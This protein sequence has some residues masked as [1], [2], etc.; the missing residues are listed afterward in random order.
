MKKRVIALLLSVML[1]L[2]LAACGEKDDG[3]GKGS[4]SKKEYE[5]IAEDYVEAFFDGDSKAIIKL[6]DDAYFES[7]AKNQGD[8]DKDEAKE[9][10]EDTLETQMQAFSAAMSAVNAD[11][12]TKAAE[13]RN[14][15][16]DELEDIQSTLESS[17]VDVEIE[18]LKIVVVAVTVEAEVDGDK[19]KEKFE[20]E[21]P[22]M[23]VDG[24]WSLEFVGALENLGEA[25]ASL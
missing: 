24:E 13:S 15:S 2:T 9:Y 4:G 23:K 12:T 3:G 16:D 18:E 5:R 11:V 6:V 19:D 21:I 25:M 14:A 20:A 17:S 10:L 7:I 8:M 1:V 22:V